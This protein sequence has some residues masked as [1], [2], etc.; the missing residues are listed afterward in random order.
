MNLDSVAKVAKQPVPPKAPA[1]A[2]KKAAAKKAATKAAAS[3]PKA[4]APVASP[5]YD[6]PDLPSPAPK[7]QASAAQ[8]AAVVAVPTGASGLSDLICCRLL[9]P[10]LLLGLVLDDV[11]VLWMPVGSVI[12]A[13]SA[14]THPVCP[15]CGMVNGHLPSCPSQGQDCFCFPGRC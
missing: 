3:G 2:P 11:L 1:A 7:E 12:L 10:V 9:C 6:L 14:G 8:A 15:F 13:P 4:A 5:T